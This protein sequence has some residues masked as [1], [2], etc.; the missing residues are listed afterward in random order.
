MVVGPLALALALFAPA[1]APPL[2]VSDV[3]LHGAV[4]DPRAARLLVDGLLGRP[5]TDA[6]LQAAVE[7]LG[8][9]PDTGQIDVLREPTRDGERVVFQLTQPRTWVDS[10]VVT[11][12]GDLDEGIAL[13]RRADAQRPL[14]LGV[15]RAWHPFLGRLDRERL[16]D[17]Y[18]QLG[19]LQ[20]TA[21]AVVETRGELTRVHLSL[22]PGP[23]FVFGEVTVTGVPEGLSL[24]GALGALTAG[25]P[26]RSEPIDAA[27]AELQGRLCAHGHPDATVVPT[28]R[29]VD[30]VAHVTLA[31]TAGPRIMVAHRAVSGLT[32]PDATLGAVAVGAPWCPATGDRVA[33]GV[34]A[35]LRSTGVLDPEVLVRATRSPAGAAVTVTSRR[36]ADATVKRVWFEGAVV[37]H[38]RVLRQLVVLREGD[39]PTPEAIERSL[40]NLR[41]SGLF[42]RASARLL[43]A[44]DGSG[45]Y[46]WFR[47]REWELITINAGQKSVTLN[48]MNL[49][50]VPR[51]LSEPHALWRGAGQRIEIRTDTDWRATTLH[52]PYALPGLITQITGEKRTF[53]W[54]FVTETTYAGRLGVGW[55]GLNN[56]FTLLPV[57]G[58]AYTTPS[59]PSTHDGL[60]LRQDEDLD[61]TVALETRLDL[62]DADGERIAYRGGT[63][64]LTVTTGPRPAPGN[65]L[66]WL[67]ATARLQGNVPIWRNGDGQHIVGRL[68]LDAGA[69]FADGPTRGWQRVAYGVRGYT[70]SSLRARFPLPDESDAGLAGEHAWRGSAE[71]RVPLPARRHAITAFF[72]AGSVAHGDQTPWE[73]V[74]PSAGLRYVFSLFGERVEGYAQATLA[75]RG[76]DGIATE[77]FDVGGGGSF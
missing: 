11:V 43:P 24:H 75:L 34:A 71:V 36:R 21:E 53:R 76:D 62:S 9:R 74:Y 50:R 57:L 64:G 37:T 47:V 30:G 73:D 12:D 39:A 65:D 48:N 5:A 29:Q 32:V 14:A 28:V 52:D 66:P 33:R 61:V 25:A 8:E 58:V 31:A 51:S 49:L 6:A 19:H 69:L 77:I 44:R 41:R 42:R 2:P 26:A 27:A 63:L 23:R 20:A 40:A 70:A 55:R 38:E 18:R 56:R 54:G 16:R 72:E 1:V 7:R 68:T 59:A 15:G 10:Y 22:H 3:S 46:V 13:V 4:S 60:P 67:R 35:W 17:T 45:Y